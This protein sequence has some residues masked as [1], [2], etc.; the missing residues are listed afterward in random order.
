MPMKALKIKLYTNLST[1]S[2]GD[3]KKVRWITWPK[4]NICFG[5]NRENGR[6]IEINVEKSKKCACHKNYDK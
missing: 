4:S 3:S 5:E 1:L 6:Q 2:T